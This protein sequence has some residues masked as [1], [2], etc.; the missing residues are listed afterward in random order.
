[1][2]GFGF[3]RSQVADLIAWAQTG[4]GALMTVIGAKLRAIVT[5]GDYATPQQAA[6]AAIGKAHFVAPGASVT[7][8]VPTDVATWDAALAAIER[9]VIPSDAMVT[10]QLPTGQIARATPIK[11]RGPWGHR[12]RTLGAA[13]VVTTA[14][15]IGAV[16]GAAGAWNMPL[17]LASVAGVAV[18]DYAIVRNTVG[19]GVH[20]MIAGIHRVSALAGSVATL[21]N[22]ARCAAWPAATLTGADVVILKTVAKFTGCDGIQVDGPVG[23]I[24]K[25]AVVGDKTAG[26]IGLITN[27][28]AIGMKGQGRVSLGS[29]FGV[30]SFGDGCV[31][32]QY[33]G[34]VDA[35]YLC[36]ADSLV[37]NALAQHGGHLY[38]NDGI[39]S[40]G[41]ASGGTG[42]GIA[43]T[44]TGA[45]SAE[46]AITCGNGAFGMWALAG[47]AI[48]AK[49]A[50]AW[51]NVS[52]NIRAD[53]G[54][55]IRG[56]SL[57]CK[58]GAGHGA[59]AISGGSIVAPGL[60][61]SNNS[62]VGTYAET[63]F[64]HCASGISQNNGSYGY[65]SD[66]GAINAAGA[67]ASGNGINGFTATHNG[68]ILASGAV[69]TGNTANSFSA[70]DGGNIRATGAAANAIYA[71]T[72]GVIDVTGITGAPAITYGP[73]GIIVDATT[74]RGSMLLDAASNF[75]IG[76]TNAAG[77]NM[78][79]ASNSFIR[80]ARGGA[81]QAMFGIDDG[82]AGT[83]M[84]GAAAGDAV[85]RAETKLWFSSGGADRGFVD[86]TGSAALGRPSVPTASTDGFFYLS[87]CAGTPT[88]VPTAK[89]GRAPMIIDSNANKLWAYVGG[90]WKSITLT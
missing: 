5:D 89:T 37:Y 17:T 39:S 81:Y 58:Y 53:Y 2:S 35:Q 15:A 23:C 77:F 22:T 78:D 84:T 24:D 20:K 40:G 90:S 63:G 73:N 32:A 87:T 71:D 31:Y 8:T 30:S 34:V 70:N 28:M 29:S 9:W 83:L 59:M 7:L 21:T 10:I 3:N 4:T 79:R 66:G 51:G 57:S 75:A 16:T 25:M 88:G 65:F 41:N 56:D 67:T 33:G 74:K 82:G 64:I 45:V 60:D 76:A 44:N 11:Y 43:A 52:V 50:Y 62:G 61:T 6:I 86:S 85:L 68:T 1:M 14:T 55:K 80:L 69:A 26:T 12:V 54:G 46:N 19:T 49:N 47:G 36:V 42:A 13:P 72:E 18:G 27:R 38:M 48:L